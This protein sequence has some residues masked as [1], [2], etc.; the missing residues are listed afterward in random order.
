MILCVSLLFNFQFSFSSSL[1]AQEPVAPVTRWLATVDEASQQVLL[2]WSP[3]ADS[4]TLGYHVCTGIPCLDYDTVYGR[5][6]TML[7]CPDHPPTMPHTYRI[8]VF[9]SAFNVSS[10]TPSF[11]N[12][13][14]SADVPRCSTT[15][16]ASWTPYRGMPGGVRRYQLLVRCEPYDSDYLP[17]VDVDSIGPLSYS[18]DIPDG[19]TH[20]WLKVKAFGYVDSLDNPPLVSQ[21]NLVKVERLT[22]DTAAFLSITSVVYDS[23]N[24]RNIILFDLDT[25]FHADHYTLRRSI[26][27]SP[28]D[29]IANP[30]FT[31]VPF[32]FVDTHIDPYDSLYCYNLSVLDACGLNPKFSNTQC[33]VIPTPLPPVWA[34]PNAILIGHPDNGS[35]LP[36]LRGLKGDLYE[37]Y[38]YNRQGIL[39]FSSTDP[40]VGWTPSSD[41][42]QGAYAYA[43]RCR[44]NNNIVKIF[45]GS[46]TV[47]K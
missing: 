12:M 27:G 44:F 3:S 7:F 19:A 13:V 40:S 16:S 26:D 20:V 45:T 39:I 30:Y 37:L 31:E 10:L 43:L 23:I 9:D 11:G 5:L 38:I 33:V 32:S 42:P 1:Q 14:L 34:F 18:F 28:W 17:Y 47:I 41:T 22:V 29:T 36:H 15:V 24:G 46:V 35:F 4:A 2:I 6:D 21:S 8:H 25:S